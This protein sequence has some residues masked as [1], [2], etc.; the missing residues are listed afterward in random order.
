[1]K[2]LALFASLLI[3]LFAPQATEQTLLAQATEI[4]L[5]APST[6]PHAAMVN[7]VCDPSKFNVTDPYT[8]TNVLD[9]TTALNTWLNSEYTRIRVTEANATDTIVYKFPA[10]TCYRLD[11]SQA[12]GLV[13]ANKNNIRIEGASHV[14]TDTNGSPLPSTNADLIGVTPSAL[15]NRDD[16]G[17]PYP[18]IKVTTVFKIIRQLE[19]IE[20]SQN[21]HDLGYWAL[22][23]Q[24][25]GKNINC[26]S[27][28][29]HVWVQNSSNITLK[30]LRV[31]GENLT[32]DN[33]GPTVPVWSYGSYASYWEFENGFDIHGGS[34]ITL[35][36]LQVRG[37]W[38]DGIANQNG[39]NGLT[40]KNFKVSYNG[41]QGL[42]IGWAENVTIENAQILNS[43]RS[44]FDLEPA[45]A[46]WFIRH[47]LIKNSYTRQTGTGWAI[48]GRGP[49]DDITIVNNKMDGAG[50][51]IIVQEGLGQQ[52][53][54][55]RMYDNE[56]VSNFGSPLA[57]V[58]FINVTNIDL[59]RNI[60]H[61]RENQSRNPIMLSGVR[62][63]VIIKDND[64]SDAC[65]V[66]TGEAA[67]A[68]LDISGNTL[69]DPATC[70]SAVMPTPVATTT[71][72]SAPTATSTNVPGA[73]STPTPT[74]TATMTAT[75]T[76]VATEPPWIT[77][78]A[79]PL[80]E[81][82][83][84][85]KFGLQT[86][87]HVADEL[88]AAGVLYPTP[89]NTPTLT[90]TPTNTATP[91]PTFTP[92][93]TATPTEV[94]VALSDNLISYWSLENVNDSH[95]SNNLTNNNTVTFVTGKVANAG[96]FV[97]ASSQYLSIANNTSLEAGDIDFTW[98]G[99]VYLTNTAAARTIMAKWGAGADGDYRLQFI[100][101][102][103]T[104]QF[105]VRNAANSATVTATWSASVSAAT[106]YY[107]VVRHDATANIISISVN[108]GTPVTA[109]LTGGTRVSANGFA[110]GALN[111]GATFH[112]G[113]LDEAGW[114]KRY[115]ADAELTDLYNGGAGRD[116]AYID[117]A[118]GGV[119]KHFAYYQRM[120]Q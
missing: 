2:R 18:E 94:P 60:F 32:Y 65:W 8:T 116:K 47:V 90:P 99:W 112:N 67:S 80:S 59:Q 30:G 81:L 73:T 64:L 104:F 69:A 63:T 24:F 57:P 1:M 23:A 77:P 35:E 43:R 111:T 52:R 100:T 118:V 50:G 41:R 9:A 44:G 6:I 10:N 54:D 42:T 82:A 51:V 92:T 74:P 17:N 84:T 75:A 85:I 76:P 110:L 114:W 117:G 109:A 21:C 120:R 25:N 33:A 14:V 16:L 119:P 34:N 36:N 101:A 4:V 95:G 70:S 49:V 115:L 11:G 46:H 3:T 26:Y 55:Y 19:L 113:G 7:G 13:I 58:R 91:T 71:P 102:G 61:V 53:H 105:A 79:S 103:T 39:T 89:T 15:P 97:S 72:P 29:R 62:G 20:V 108:A 96:N 28:R 66:W 107:V 56:R 78:E 22:N 38:G 93:P 40:I 86:Y 31:E 37:V 27:K 87:P 12:G 83:E 88:V 45:A 5:N 106:W 48:L 98:A 68:T